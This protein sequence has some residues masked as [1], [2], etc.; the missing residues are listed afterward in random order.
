MQIHPRVFSVK[1]G[2]CLGPKIKSRSPSLKRGGGAFAPPGGF[3]GGSKISE[4]AKVHISALHR[5]AD[6]TFEMLLGQVGVTHRHLQCAVT[7]QLGYQ[8]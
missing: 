6:R 3:K 1:T 8:P 7:Q 4:G 5:L 2:L